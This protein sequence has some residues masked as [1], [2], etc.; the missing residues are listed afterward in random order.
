MYVVIPES[1]GKNLGH[2]FVKLVE[3]ISR[4]SGTVFS[5]MNGHIVP[6]G[7]VMFVEIHLK[8]LDSGD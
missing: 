2:C 7:P 5:S 8:D 6:D 4:K 1:G 3:N